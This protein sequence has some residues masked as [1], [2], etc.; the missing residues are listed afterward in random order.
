MPLPSAKTPSS[1]TVPPSRL[2]AIIGDMLQ[3]QGVIA[4]SL[5]ISY[6]TNDGS[7]RGTIYS[8]KLKDWISVTAPTVSE[9]IFKLKG[10]L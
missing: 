9:L 8:V 2:S 3:D 7:F 4:T 6:L 10:E 1:I 5:N